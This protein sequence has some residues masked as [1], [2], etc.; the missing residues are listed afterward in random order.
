MAGSLA[1][2]IA[3]A[4]LA[5]KHNAKWFSSSS[6]RY[7]PGIA[8]A[9]NNPKVGEV[10]GCDA[11]SPCSTDPT[12]P[13]LYWYGIHGVETLFTIMGS[14]CVSVSRA[15]SEGT[16]VVTGVWSDGRIG[17][18]RGIRKGARSFG[19]TVFGTKGIVQAGEFA[20]YPPLIVEIARFF[21]TGVVPIAPEQTI[22]IL[23]FM[24]A[25]DESKKEGGK[26]VTIASVMEKA[27][28]KAETLVK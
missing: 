18:F 26:P 22:E 27:K 1:E 23:A 10:T 13:D 7:T 4:E 20:G 25:A 24:D 5:K 21:K 2:G 19:A 28:A 9:R 11:W 8:N 3:I 15:G 16:D 6:L 14:G 12:V 17:T